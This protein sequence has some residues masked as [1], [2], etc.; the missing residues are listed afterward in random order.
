M[1]FDDTVAAFLGAPDPHA[2]ARLRRQIQ[3]DPDYSTS[4]GSL[5]EAAALLDD[6]RHGEAVA[7]L[8]RHRRANFLS[9][10]GHLLF[11]RALAAEGR[12]ELADLEEDLAGV[13]LETLLASGTGERHRP[14]VVLRVSDEYDVASRLAFRH[15]RQAVEVAGSRVLDVFEDAD[16]TSLWFELYRGG[17]GDARRDQA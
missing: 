12:S 16:G 14:Y 2:L 6:G 17:G 7:L 15:T 4:G 1:D 10:R 8:A 9:P 11:S 3:T 5:I 13:A